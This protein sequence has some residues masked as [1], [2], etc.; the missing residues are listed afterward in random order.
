MRICRSAASPP[1]SCEACQTER[2]GSRIRNDR[3]I[4]RIAQSRLY[5]DVEDLDCLGKAMTGEL[6]RFF[7]TYN[8]LKGKHFQVTAVSDPA[9]ACALIEEASR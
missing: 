8:I 7:E 1:S 6:S 5:A 2:D 9:R 4:G 3:L